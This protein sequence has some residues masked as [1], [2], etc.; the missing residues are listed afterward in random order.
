MSNCSG[1][2]CINVSYRVRTQ[3]TPRT[4]VVSEAFGLGVDEHE[5]HIVYDNLRIQVRPTDIVYI[6]G[7]SGSG[8]S[9]LLKALEKRSKQNACNVSNVHIDFKKAL[10]DTVGWRVE[11]GLELL[12]RV[13]LNDAF[14]FVRRYNQL[15][16]GQRY[17]YRIAKMIESKKQPLQYGFLSPSFLMYRTLSFST[18]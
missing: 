13:G 11:A 9:T 7:Q 2:F 8:K 3:V 12:S 5:Q 6:I 14:L 4:A 16:D 18:V 1:T 10:I 17:R 15:S